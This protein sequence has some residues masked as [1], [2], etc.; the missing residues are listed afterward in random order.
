[1]R[2]DCEVAVSFLC[3]GFAISGCGFVNLNVPLTI[4]E[5][6]NILLSN[7]QGA[8]AEMEFLDLGWTRSDAV[9]AQSSDID[10]TCFGKR[11]QGL[12]GGIS[13]CFSVDAQDRITWHEILNGT[14]W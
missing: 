14:Y 2:D 13:S 9:A 5:A 10:K 7:E 6:E 4:S 12:G 3:L 1:M 11:V 8:Q